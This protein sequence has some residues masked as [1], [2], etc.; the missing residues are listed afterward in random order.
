MFQEQK[1]E[2]KGSFEVKNSDSDIGVNF[3][4]CWWNRSTRIE[5]HLKSK[6]EAA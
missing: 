3:F 6:Y 1:D 4:P 5:K 2:I